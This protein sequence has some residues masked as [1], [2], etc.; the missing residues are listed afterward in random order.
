MAFCFKETCAVMQVSSSRRRRRRR[1]FFKVLSC[2]AFVV[3][4]S[5][6]VIAE[7]SCNDVHVS[8]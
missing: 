5:D 4:R 1:V 6:C 8:V 3:D 7:G 2:I